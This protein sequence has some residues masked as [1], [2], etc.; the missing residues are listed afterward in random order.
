METRIVELKSRNLKLKRLVVDV[1]QTLQLVC[2]LLGIQTVQGG[3][4]RR[5]LSLMM[6]LCVVQRGQRSTCLDGCI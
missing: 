1:R 2:N 4:Q 5:S 3:T 6:H